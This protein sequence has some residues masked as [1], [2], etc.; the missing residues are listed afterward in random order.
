MP[1]YPLISP[2]TITE[3]DVGVPGLWQFDP[4]VSHVVVSNGTG[5]VAKIEINTT[6]PGV[7]T[8]DFRVADGE[9][10]WLTPQLLEGVSIQYLGAVLL[11]TRAN[12]HARGI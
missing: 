7:P 12:F 9:N 6:S 1:A 10:L 5:Q 3:P 8:A 11:G 2:T 4:P